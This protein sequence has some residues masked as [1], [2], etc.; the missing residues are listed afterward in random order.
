MM[1]IGAWFW[2]VILAAAAALVVT[3]VAFLPEPQRAAPAPAPEPSTQEQRPTSG[4][5]I[6]FTGTN[7][8][9][10]RTTFLPDANE[11]TTAGA[12]WEDTLDNI[13]G[14]DLDEATTTRQLVA[15][16]PGLPPE[17][18]EEFI[19]HALNLCDD[20]QFAQME[21]I[22]LSTKTPP[23]V[24]EVIFD[25][26]LNRSDEVKL[27]LMAKSLGNTGHPMREESQEIL[28]MFLDLEPGQTPPGGWEAAVQK[29]LR[30]EAL[31]E[32]S[33]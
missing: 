25:D 26:A 15:A 30:E 6:S 12:A 10:G 13:L 31:S 7:A 4:P 11:P 22:Y 32:Q 29:Y 3:F 14:S 17:A 1:K 33:P 20:A 23:A 24:A 21:V 9:P 28:E 5:D 16:L 27:P 18:Q 19:A 8:P 2:A